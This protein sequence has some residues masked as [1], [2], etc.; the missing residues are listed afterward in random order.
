MKVLFTGSSSFTGYWFIQSLAKSG[1]EVIA[2]FQNRSESYTGVRKKRVDAL[3]NVCSTHF[4]CP[5]GSPAFLK[6]IEQEVHWDLLC[7]HAANVTNYKSPDFD[8]LGALSQN[9]QNVMAVL[10][11]LQRKECNKILLTGSVFEQD[12]GAGS[13]TSRAFSPYGLSKGLTYQVFRY[14]AE[15]LQMKLGK[16]VIP[17]PFGP[18]EEPRFTSY[19]INSW[20]EGKIPTVAT[21][22]YVRDNIHVDLLAKG[23]ASFA[24]KLRGDAGQEFLHPSGYPESQGAFTQR[25]SQEMGKRL[26]FPCPFELLEQREFLEPRVRI[27]TDLL[28]PHE[29]KWSEKDAWDRLAAYYLQQ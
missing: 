6:L 21:P 23:Y 8:I 17:N 9:T 29:H 24:E 3:Q 12:E 20:K 13:G 5:F 14:Q 15:M 16:F 1:H 22:A 11:A 26:P 27:N 2:T 7:H 25:F 28:I 10:K 19:L 18:Y 4:E